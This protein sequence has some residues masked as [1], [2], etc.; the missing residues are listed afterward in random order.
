MTSQL[1]RRTFTAAVAAAPLLLRAQGTSSQPVKLLVGFPPGGGTDAIARTFADRL[2]DILGMPVVVDNK[3]GAGGQIAAQALKAAAPD[4]HTFFLSHDHSISILPLVTKNA[5]FEPATDFIPASGFATFAN[6]LALS[7]G[8]PAKT[9]QDYIALVQGANGKDT[10]GVPAPASIPEFLVGM[11]ASKY[12]LDL[13]A[14]PY[15]GS[16]PM[17]ADMLGNQIRAGVASIPDF[18]ENHRAG[19]LR[20][21]A[22]IGDKRQPILPDVPTFAELGLAGLED[23]PYY[24]F[25]A[26]AGTPA[27]VLD[28][29][30]QAVAK[31][32][33]M[34]DVRERLTNMG[35]AVGYQPQP[36]FAARVKG[37]T[38]N[39]EKIIKASGFVAK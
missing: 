22:V 16:A 15:R 28:R 10:I 3:A 14:A 6:A 24:G 7:G 35:L 33:A 19:K 4:G 37:Y 25:F 18:I 39:W 11:L 34:P 36:Q 32:V 17:M 8:T 29:F 9:L 20:V 1:T 5:G 27:A 12:K 38:Q 2:K 21:V 31:A 26:P 30:N 23:L 13:Q